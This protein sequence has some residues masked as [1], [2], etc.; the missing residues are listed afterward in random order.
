MKHDKEDLWKAWWASALKIISFKGPDEI[1]ERKCFDKWYSDKFPAEKV[2]F[3]ISMGVKEELQDDGIIKKSPIIDTE[4]PKAH[5]YLFE[6]CIEGKKEMCECKSKEDCPYLVRRSVRGNILVN[7]LDADFE[8]FTTSAFAGFG[9]SKV[10]KVILTSN[11]TE[12]SEAYKELYDK[13]LAI[14]G[15]LKPIIP[16]WYDEHKPNLDNDTTFTIE[17][18]ITRVFDCKICGKADSVPYIE[19]EPW[20]MICNDCLVSLDSVIK[21]HNSYDQN[22]RSTDK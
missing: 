9:T 5:K 13:A 20:M 18:T 10:S 3:S 14:K 4:I 1:Y 19:N 22:K 2:L 12:G 8:K 15:G 21:L 11:P 16:H 7:N 6:P 17:D